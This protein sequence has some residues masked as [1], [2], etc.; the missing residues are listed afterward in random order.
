[1]KTALTIAL[2]GVALAATLSLVPAD[3]TEPAKT[4]AT[5]VLPADE[6]LTAMRSMGLDPIGRPLRRG[7]YYVMHAYDP[8]GVEVRVVA[9]AQLGDIVSVSPARALNNI[10]APRYEHAPRI[11]HVPQRGE[12]DEHTGSLDRHPPDAAGY[13]DD[14]RAVAPARH[15]ATSRVPLADGPT[16]IRPTPRFDAK[17]HDPD[18]ASAPDNADKPPPDNDPAAMEL[19]RGN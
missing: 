4:L 9:D 16:P 5:S 11:I 8:Y 2:A 19:P 3:S 17:A 12:S 15:R 10:Y 14:E 1:M 18:K 7:H 13:D 6:I